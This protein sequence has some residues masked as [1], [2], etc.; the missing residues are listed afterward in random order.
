[1]LIK[2]QKNNQQPIARLNSIYQSNRGRT[3]NASHI[4]GKNTIFNLDVCVGAQVCL[5]IANI[6]PIAGLYVGSIGRVVEI[7]YDKEYTVGPNG[8]RTV[9]SHLPK[10]IVVD[11]PHFKPP[12]GIDPWDRNNPTVS[13]KPETYI[14]CYLQNFEIYRMY[15]ISLNSKL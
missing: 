4:K 3:V 8:D 5:E 6:N 15:P 14:A 13:T 9:L 2:T 11:F 1:M 7:V 10:Y 12:Q